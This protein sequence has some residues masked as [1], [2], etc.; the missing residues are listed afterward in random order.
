MS[1]QTH[2]RACPLCEAICGLLIETDGS[3][4]LSIKGDPEDPLS[5]GHI[6]PK[7]VALRDIH[8]DPDRLRQPLQRVH[9]ANGSSE[10]RE[11]S[12]QEALDTTAQRLVEIARRDGVDTIGIYLGNPTVHNYGMMTHQRNL[13]RHFR[14]KN[15]FSAT[16]VD[17]LPH[18]LVALWLFGHKSLLPIPDIDRCDYF[19]MLGANPLASNGSIWTVPDVRKRIKALQRRGGKLVVIDPR[20]TET[21]QLASEH[22]FINPGSDALFLLALLQ[23]LFAEDLI[24]P[25]HLAEFVT[26]LDEVAAAVAGF[27]PEFAQPHTGIDAATTR[28]IAREFATAG[29]GICYGR[30][31]VSTQRHG[32]LCQWLIQILNIATGNLDRPGGS[33]FTLPAVDLVGHSNPGGFARH[34][35]RVR[36]LPEFDRELPVAAL[37]EEITTPGQ[38]QIR[39]L[40][41]GAGNPVLSTPN[42]RQLDEALTGLEFMVCLDPYLNETTRHADIILP[43]TSPLEHDHYDLAFHINAIR[44][45]ARHSEAVFPR[46]EGA[47]HDWEIFAELGARVAVLLGEEAEPVLAP[48]V[49][50]DHGLQSGPYSASQGSVQA[51]SLAR[52]REQPS[53]IDLGPLQPQL[54]ARLQTTDRRINCATPQVLDELQR[55]R[56]SCALPD[57]DRL[58]LIGR[59][60]LRSNNSWMHNYHRLVKGKPRCTLLMH[61]QDMQARN[62]S[63]GTTVTVRSRTAALT[64]T[65]EASNDIMPGVVSL[66]HGFGHDRPGAR[67]HTA[68][69]HAGV[70]CN[71]ITDEQQLDLLSGN[72]AING[73]PVTV[74]TA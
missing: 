46:P 47:L 4:I 58:Q 16:S 67:L 21:A 28:R 17:Q 55:L 9:A 13:F 71:D 19:L 40:F 7:A 29:A 15:R 41:V 2:H 26:G 61:P 64:A 3:E 8:E 53:G 42:G 48:D 65:V 24:S 74:A 54:P 51:L 73:V 12:W 62:I 72:A 25:A 34:H 11:I 14:S 39:A 35:S 68:A 49:I 43:P 1:T 38:G 44:N 27:T 69:R 10:W 5:R 37:A 31:G 66:P 57:D 70:S 50:I 56:E 18:H 6:C 60:H 33:L 36:Q 32:T 23:T 59:R 45:T 20:R 30:M 22:H 52:L 63:E